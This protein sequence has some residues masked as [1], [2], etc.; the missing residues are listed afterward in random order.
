MLVHGRGPRLGTRGP[1]LRTAVALLVLLHHVP[2]MC[3]AQSS[4]LDIPPVAAE[5]P[6]W[7][8]PAVAQMV[9]TYYRIPPVD[10]RA[11]WSRGSI[12]PLGVPTTSLPYQCSIVGITNP[13]CG[14]DCQSC[15]RVD[16]DPRRALETFF[17]YPRLASESTR[18][19]GA[20]LDPILKTAALTAADVAVAI[21]EYRS[22]MVLLFRT[23]PDSQDNRAILVVG[24][25]AIPPM[26]VVINDPLGST[27]PF[28]QT[29]PPKLQLSVP[30]DY[31]SAK[32]LPEA[33]ISFRP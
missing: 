25:E 27:D 13:R 7:S 17:E 3:L 2:T 1:H 26:R 16:A 24:V 9:F 12:P 5:H 23:G 6:G 21:K 10:P 31:F 29:L 4:L 20:L 33:T 30:W 22:P 14:L 28:F 19:R 11:L 18:T 32:S 15:R 8:L